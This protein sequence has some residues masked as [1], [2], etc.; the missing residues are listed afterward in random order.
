MAEGTILVGCGAG[1]SGDRLDAPG[2]VVATLARSGRP[3]AIMFE[4]LGERTLAL[5]QLDRMR[6][7]ERG[8]EPLLE[9]LL[10]PILAACL[11]HGIRI[12]GNFGAANPRAAARRILALGRRLGCRPMRVAVVTGDDVT[13]ALLDGAVEDAAG[14]PLRVAAPISANAYLGA[15]PLVEALALGADIVVAGRVADPALALAPFMHHHGWAEDDWRR[16][17]CGTLAGHLLECGS[18]VSGGYFA[19]PGVK[20]VPDPH[21]IGFPIAAMEADGVFTIGKAD[22]T[23]GLV[24]RR[25][26][27]EQI[28]Y[29][30]HDPAAYLT[31]DVTL[32][33][34]GVVLAEA[35]A[36]RVRVTGAAGRPRPER[37]KVTVGYD[38]GWLGEGEISYAGPNAAARARLALDVV[39]RRLPADCR[40]RGDIVGLCSV[41]GDDAGGG[42]A[43][44][45]AQDG[46]VRL[47]IAVATPERALAERAAQEVLALYTCGP[48]GGGGVRSAVRQ[49]IA[50]ASG[51]VPRSLVRPAVEILG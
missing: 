21:D 35:G 34:T 5:A 29:E 6:D 12:L 24:D 25:T 31:P 7:P 37:L 49:R 36:D 15:A 51:Y 30:V 27:T 14:A 11:D 48:A 19:D 26:V 20:D 1:F 3:A 9:P 38:G 2:P 18:Q 39:R 28:L 40:M 8:Y 44:A 33:I 17:A 16:I 43:E 46:D 32:D 22:R 13:A 23:G 41:F 50:T 10:E 47:R 4:T 45:P 42:L